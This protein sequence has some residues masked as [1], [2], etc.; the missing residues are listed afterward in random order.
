MRPFSTSI[1]AGGCY[2]ASS[3]GK[4]ISVKTSSLPITLTIGA[5][6]FTV[7][8]GSVIPLEGDINFNFTNGNSI[9][10]YLYFFVGDDQMRFSP[11]DNSYSINSTYALGCMGNPA[12]YL[13]AKAGKATDNT[14]Y[15]PTNGKTFDVTRNGILTI[16]G[17]NN[18][19]RRKQIT[20]QNSGTNAVAIFDANANLF[21]IIPGVT[22]LGNIGTPYT[23]ETDS[24][25]Y[26]CGLNGLDT[27]KFVVNELYY[28]SNV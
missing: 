5:Q 1:P 9:P 24:T 28:G 18:L 13:T 10:V 22:V 26:A 7:R 4:F 11:D 6:S 15:D 19:H 27:G 8:S 25:F 12:G 16:P 17:V 2:S 23:Y 21:L 14:N 20:F 3:P